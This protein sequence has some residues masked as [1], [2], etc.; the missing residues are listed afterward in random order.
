MKVAESLLTEANSIELISERGSLPYA[1][2]VDI[3]RELASSPVASTAR[4]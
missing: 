4:A 1:D 3:L 2:L